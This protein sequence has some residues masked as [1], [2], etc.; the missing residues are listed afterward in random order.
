MLLLQDAV[1]RASRSSSGPIPAGSPHVIAIVGL[2]D[3]IVALP[4]TLV[5]RPSTRA[6][7]ERDRDLVS[8]A[9]AGVRLQQSIERRANAI[10]NGFR[11][12]TDSDRRPD[13]T[14]ENAV[15]QRV[16]AR[17]PMNERERLH[18][19]VGEIGGSAGA[20]TA[21]HRRRTET[22]AGR[23]EL[24]RR[25]TRAGLV[26]R[27]EEDSVHTMAVGNVPP[28][29]GQPSRPMPI[30]ERTRSPL[31]WDAGSDRRR[32]CI[33]RRRTIEP[34]TA[35]SPRRPDESRSGETRSRA[36]V[37]MRG[38]RSTPMTAE[39]PRPAAR[40]ATT[41]ATGSDVQHARAVYHRRRVEQRSDRVI[42]HRGEEVRA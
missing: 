4:N 32:N 7:L 31:A 21:R 14:A 13:G 30:R 40:N 23:A 3:M 42:R 19:H 18:R 12:A 34:R 9:F 38:A 27:I 39:A 36:S 28:G 26:H 29:K 11:L 17:Q 15:P 41:P 35:G 37:T 8:A 1:R 6:D 10:L 2:P 24:S 25:R 20:R 16:G 33:R 5:G 22:S